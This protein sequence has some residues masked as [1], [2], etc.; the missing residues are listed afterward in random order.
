MPP[1]EPALVPG[2]VP[3]R[4][5][6]GPDFGGLEDSSFSYPKYVMNLVEGDVAVT[7]G[8]GYNGTSPG[9]TVQFNIPDPIFSD[10]FEAGDVNAWS[11]SAV[12]RRNAIKGHPGR[13]P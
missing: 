4:V 1:P 10:W 7:T 9:P 8:D 2:Q 3:I 13:L 6:L 5:A 11:D 12:G